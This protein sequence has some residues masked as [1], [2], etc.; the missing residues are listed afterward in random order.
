[1]AAMTLS[2]TARGHL[3]MLA[4]SLLIAG[5]FTFGTRIAGLMDPMTLTAIRFALAGALVGA[6]A[7]VRPGIRAA[8]FRAP[9]RYGVLGGLFAF[10][11]AVMFVGLKTAAPVSAA[12]VFT[13]TPAMSAVFGYLLLGQVTTRWMALALAVGAL[14]AGW[15]IFRGDLRAA[16]AFDVGRGEAIYFV[17]CIAHA[18]YTPMVRRLNRGEPAVVFT[19]GMIVAGFA[20]LAVLS[21]RDLVSFDYGALPPVFWVGLAYLAVCSSAMTFYLLQYATLVLPSANVMAYTYLTPSWVIVWEI[22]FGGALPAPVVWIGVAVTGI[23]LIMLLR[24]VR[25]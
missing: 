11:F 16:L 18:I 21:V 20:I 22:A 13:L 14:G 9:W 12:A 5:S 4:F 3:A 2:P 10:Y 19:L 7:A 17:A 8:H 15:V 6:F 1:M 25:A 23:A 24:P